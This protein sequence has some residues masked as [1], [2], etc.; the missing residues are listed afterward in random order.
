MLLGRLRKPTDQMLTEVAVGTSVVGGSEYAGAGG[1]ISRGSI[2]RIPSDL[3]RLFRIGVVNRI[4][5]VS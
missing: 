4:Y 1:T 3:N 2:S 5:L